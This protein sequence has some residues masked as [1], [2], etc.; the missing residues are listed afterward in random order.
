MIDKV[1][2]NESNQDPEPDLNSP[3]QVKEKL[4]YFRS[5]LGRTADLSDADFEELRQSIKVFFN[6]KPV[7]YSKKLPQH[8]VRISNNNRILEGQ[9]KELSYLTDI[10]QLLAPP[11]EFCRYGR[12]N[13]P[14]QQ[15]LYCAMDEATAY[16]EVR[17]EYGDVITI[18]HYSL[19]PNAQAEC[20]VI[21]PGSATETPSN[22]SELQKIFH[23]LDDFFVDVFTYEVSRDRPK[24][25]LIS[26]LLSSEQL[27]YPVP[28]QDNIQA[29]IYPSVQK[30]QFGQNI[31][32]RN[33][34][35][36]DKYDLAGVET[37]F[38]LDSL[39]DVMPSSNDLITDNVI[40]SF[41][42][43]V[44]DI[45]HGKILYN[46]EAPKLFKLFREMQIG[47]G[48]QTRI[49]HPDNPEIP[50]N[51]AFDLSPKTAVRTA[52][53]KKL[54]YGRNDRVNVI[55]VDGTRVNNVKHKKVER[56]ID[57]GKCRIV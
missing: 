57:D 46:E 53:A 51:M 21:L 13:L 16:W 43:K 44:F 22:P 36:F 52:P 10:S 12:C 50:K 15:I 55:Y 14:N 40:G 11:P 7:H 34:I 42:T 37:R 8:L 26:A 3:E 56:D 48:K 45:E 49:E 28:S 25:Y 5:L 1:A 6:L 27:F 38:I 31:A 30:Q 35:I 32:I 2:N 47:G 41:G 17:P 19:K 33:E 4:D 24:D 18:S 23:L 9:G 39:P 20:S 29:I 54:K